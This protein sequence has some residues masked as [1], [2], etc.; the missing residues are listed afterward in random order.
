MRSLRQQAQS[1][2]IEFNRFLAENILQMADDVT[3]RH[4]LQVELQAARQHRHWNFLRVGGGENEFDMRRRLFQRLQHRIEGVVGQHVDFVDHVDLEARIGRRVHRLLQQLRHLVDAAVGRRVHLDV[5]DE[6][7]GI[8]RGAGFAYTAGLGSDAAAAVRP[9]TVERLCQNARQSSLADAARTGEQ[10]GV[11]QPTA[12]Q[13]MRKRAH[14]VLLADEL[15]KVS[16]TIFT[17]E[18]L[19]GHGV[20]LPYGAGKKFYIAVCAANLYWTMVAAPG[21][22]PQCWP[23]AGFCIS[24]LRFVS[25]YSINRRQYPLILF[26]KFSYTLHYRPYRCAAAHRDPDKDFHHAMANPRSQ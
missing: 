2:R 9:E 6:A 24:T 19:I 13:R 12:A 16:G 1:R 10:V 26:S 11:M 18:D 7:A 4:L 25:I 14:D 17:G 15:F 22:G 20:I 23:A 21:R 8:N 5:V 3:R